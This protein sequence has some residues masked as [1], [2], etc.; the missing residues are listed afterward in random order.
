MSPICFARPL[1]AVGFFAATHSQR[2]E[3]VIGQYAEPHQVPK[4]FDQL[5]AIGQL[6]GVDDCGLDGDEERGS[7]RLEVANNGAVNL[8]QLRAL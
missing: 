8:G 3:G 4:R 6:I 2:T 1:E 7:A 5:I